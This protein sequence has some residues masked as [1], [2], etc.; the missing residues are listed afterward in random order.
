MAVI[1]SLP[2]PPGTSHSR[3]KESNLPG[4]RVAWTQHN[5]YHI[6]TSPKGRSPLPLT[7][8]RQLPTKSILK[9]SVARLLA[10]QKEEQREATPEP[11]DPLVNL[12]YLTRP[13]SQILACE[14]SCTDL[15]D[16]YTVLAARI[17]SAVV[18][19][20][21]ADASWPL[22]QPI[23]KNTQPITDALC[24][25][26]GKAL[27]EPKSPELESESE[28][29]PFTCVEEEEPPSL[30]PS[31]KQSPK[32]K[33]RGMSAGQAKYA[34]DLCTT[35]H[36]VMRLLGAVFTLPAV[37]RIFTGAFLLALRSLA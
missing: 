28:D 10:V 34:R 26:L 4:S 11:E 2:T 16:A 31:P 37:Y 20:T 1:T 6:L 19:T 17:R 29:F 8:S 9:K 3:D 32:K 23:R 18:G 12:S 27:V 36:A 24:R 30:L 25:D 35:S 13:V 7:A 21:D 15:I 33:K 22:F 14:T 5:Q